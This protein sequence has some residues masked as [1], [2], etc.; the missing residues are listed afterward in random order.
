[1]LRPTD[2]PFIPFLTAVDPMSFF[3]FISFIFVS[4]YL[5]AFVRWNLISN[6]PS[7]KL[8]IRNST[9]CSGRGL[10]HNKAISPIDVFS[11]RRIIAALARCRTSNMFVVIIFLS[12][13]NFQIVLPIRIAL[14]IIFL[15]ISSLSQL[16]THN[17]CVQKT[18]TMKHDQVAAVRLASCSKSGYLQGK[19]RYA[20]Q[21]SPVQSPS[22]V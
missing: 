2:Q 17:F 16:S 20:A 19:C 10:A 3:S 6:F 9:S 18:A 5:P 12:I 15:D 14:P 1:M 21:C 7:T 11:H 8:C 22:L 4:G 13:L